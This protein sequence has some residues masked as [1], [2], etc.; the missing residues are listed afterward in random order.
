[1]AAAGWL[2]V[3]AAVIILPLITLIL[4]IIIGY[5]AQRSGFCSIGGMRDLMMFRHTRLF[6]GYLALIGSAFLGYLIFWA[7]I[8]AAFPN[9]YW[10]ASQ[11]N[12]LTPIPGA[13]GGLT[14][15]SYIIL[16]IIGG[17]GMGIL[18]VVLGGCPLRQIVMGSEGN[19][20]SIYYIIGLIIGAVIF[21]AWVV[22]WVAAV[23]P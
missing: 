3:G 20:R 1:M 10:T 11:S 23:F 14:I 5:L 21:H 6:I 4:G 17:F 15:G 7:I 9:F 2:V 8:P 13:P 19:Y 12:P 18:G 22:G 16:A